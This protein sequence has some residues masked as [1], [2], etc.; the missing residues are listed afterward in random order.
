M[1]T[2]RQCNKDIPH[3]PHASCPGVKAAPERKRSP[4]KRQ[5]GPALV[6]THVRKERPILKVEA[7][8]ADRAR[9]A[10]IIGPPPPKKVV[11][12]KHPTWDPWKN[13]RVEG[14]F[15]DQTWHELDENGEATG[16]T[17]VRK[18]MIPT[19]PERRCRATI[20]KGEWTGNRCTRASIR[21]GVVCHTHGGALASVKKAAQKRLAM[22][23]DP[24]AAKLIYIALH[25]PDTEDK[26]R[27]KALLAILDRAGIAGAEK[28][29][30]EIKPWQDVL[31]RVAGTLEGG[32]GDDVVELVEGEDYEVEYDD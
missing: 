24:A 12:K 28:I 9:A 14:P 8:A 6:E 29:E 25:K 5:P 16:R 27:I 7:R 1:A 22:A 23:A 4:A 15:E 18:R 31:R 10:G 26:D 30:L 17:E 11:P 3:Q 21:G 2:N 13:R 32:S 20:R 19:N